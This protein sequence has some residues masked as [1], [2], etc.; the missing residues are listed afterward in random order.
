ML[1]SLASAFLCPVEKLALSSIWVDDECIS[2]L[3]EKNMKKIHF[4]V[5]IGLASLQIQSLQAS[6]VNVEWLEPS[7]FRDI[8][9]ADAGQKRFAARVLNEL[10]QQFQDSGLE[11]LPGNQTL[12][13]EISDVDLAGRIDYPLW[14][15]S[16]VRIVRDI[17]FPR[18]NFSY[19]ILDETGS[20]VAAGEAE[21]KDVSFNFASSVYPGSD[22][23]GLFY[24]KKLIEDWFKNNF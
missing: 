21:I 22:R 7:T 14:R 12:S 13:V 10:S 15:T 17:D 3:L 20:I 18:I 6:E 23:D 11:Y 4:L 1:I 16:G 19:E 24:E 5:F 2:L 9:T 8:R